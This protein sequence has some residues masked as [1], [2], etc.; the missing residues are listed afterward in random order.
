MDA[1]VPDR[2]IESWII[3]GGKRG[4]DARRST[5]A[6]WHR[7]Q[8]SDSSS[9]V[10]LLQLAPISPSHRSWYM[11]TSRPVHQCNILFGQL[12]DV[13]QLHDYSAS[14][15]KKNDS[16]TP[17]NNETKGKGTLVRF[18]QLKLLNIRRHVRVSIERN[19]P[20]KVRRKP[21]WSGAARYTALKSIG[22]ALSMTPCTLYSTS[23]AE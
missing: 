5:R 20:K 19:V 18:D 15:G 2:S 10:C 12:D 22:P 11:Y 6:K 7:C 9:C 14:H 13:L 17:P 1:S 8:G 3:G 21:P 4:G 23:K 16:W